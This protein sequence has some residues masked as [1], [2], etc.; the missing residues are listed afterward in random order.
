M[1]NKNKKNILGEI[2][3]P[4]GIQLINCNECKKY[5]EEE[6]TALVTAYL[7]CDNI[8]NKYCKLIESI[9]YDFEVAYCV[10]GKKVTG[11][12]SEENYTDKYLEDLKKK[13][14][15]INNYEIKQVKNVK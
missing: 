5:S 2:K 6:Y 13:F 3:Y 11:D 15:E 7:Q 1:L 12:S 4:V 14:A 9:I 10:T 8:K